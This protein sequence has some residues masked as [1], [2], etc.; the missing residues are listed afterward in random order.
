R[1]MGRLRQVLA[2]PLYGSV[3]WLVWVVSRQAGPEGAALVLAGLVLIALAAWLHHGTRSVSRRWRRA[4]V[5]LALGCVAAA[6]ALGPMAASSASSAAAAPPRGA[7]WEPFTPERLAEPRARG[8][9]GFIN[10]T[11][12]WGLTSPGT[13]RV[14]HHSPRGPQALP[15]PSLLYL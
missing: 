3:A 15:R 11:P 7:R 2:L 6:I 14:A 9:P 1:W 5:A 4:A 13:E 8:A 10:A 12:P